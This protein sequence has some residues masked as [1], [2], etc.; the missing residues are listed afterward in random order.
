MLMLSKYW[1]KFFHNQT[2]MFRLLASILFVLPLIFSGCTS[3]KARQELQVRHAILMDTLW[4]FELAG[5]RKIVDDA[6]NAATD[7]IKRLDKIFDFYDPQSELSRINARA[8]F[9]QVEVS[10]DMA[11]C[12]KIA[13]ECAEQTD[14]AFDPSV[15]AITLL[16]LKAREQD[17][18]PE[19]PDIEKALATVSW[20]SVSLGNHGD[21]HVVN[22]ATTGLKLDLGGV[23]KGYALDRAV[24]I[25][26]KYGIDA[27]LVNAGGEVKCFGKP[28]GKKNGW[29]VGIQHPRK[30]HGKTI[31]TLVLKPGAVVST[32]GDYERKFK[33]AGRE[34][35]HLFDPKTG[36]PARRCV[37]ASVV[38]APEIE[39]N[40][41]AV[42]DCLST[43]LFVSGK[44]GLKLTGNLDA[45]AGFVVLSPQMDELE[46]C[47]NSNFPLGMLEQKITEG[48]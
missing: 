45:T 5:D 11:Q 16:W 9:E 19:K 27:G 36:Y 21:S 23:A 38:I 8:A 28:D 12:L 24:E 31:G 4:E 6:V 1:Q 32:S 44:D 17:V 48:I 13:L 37:E 30:S 7:E 42:A 39:S 43:A 47:R 2:I 10:S 15:G 46:V 14:G 3:G 22:F 29:I 35:H 18:I 26:E 41:G 33:I 25:I 34:F 20:R 40:S